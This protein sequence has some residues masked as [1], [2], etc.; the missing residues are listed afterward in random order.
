VVER[1]ASVVKELVENALDAGATRVTVEV[2]GGGVDRITVTDDGTGMDPEDARLALE[3]HAT[4]KIRTSEDLAAIGTLG[5]RG[6]ALPSIASVSRLVVTTSPDRSGL[7]TEVVA[8]RGA[9]PVVAPVRQARGTRVVVEDLFGNVPARRKF[10]KSTDAE[11]RA[12]SRVFIALALSRWDVHFTLAAKGKTLLELPAAKT[13]AER[14]S[15]LLGAAAIGEVL[16]VTASSPGLE[17]SGT[18][19]RPDVTFASKTNQWLFVNGRSVKDGAVSHAAALAARETLREDRHP[20]WL[21]FL[22]ADPALCDVNVHPQKEEVRFRDSAAVHSLIHRALGQALGE[23]KGARPLAGSSFQLRRAEPFSS[24]G[25]SFFS[26]GSAG[27]GTPVSEAISTW[28]S[29]PPPVTPAAWR[30][31]EEPA[32]S[33]LGPLRFLGQYRDSFLVAESG[34]GLVLIDQ[35]VAHERVRYE[36]IVAELG[37]REPV[38]QWLLIPVSFEATATEAL[39][40][41][42]ADSLLRGAGFLV[43]E[44][45]GRTW[46]VSAVPVETP[47]GA[48]VPFL[49]D[50][51]S[52]LTQLPDEAGDESIPA[53]AREVLAASLACR[54][55]ITINTRLR[56]EEATKLMEDLSRCADPFTC[57]HGRPIFLTLAH[58]ELE[59]RFGRSVT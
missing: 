51:L 48:I 54:G 22:K 32:V 7:G 1:P 33:P 28:L 5:F 14:F 20:G 36:R 49:K 9:R 53:R 21:L 31:E 8:D 12:I 47:S 16:E 24:P 56:P 18:L 42:R 39:A 23:G 29:P 11:L 37:Q 15:E 10:L 3:R 43:S 58:A 52:R 40:M 30:H 27:I 46:V 57:P 34:D 13:S 50:F 55:A 19:T 2:D 41:N 6:E 44:L 59:R 17:L 25:R 38:S 4:S 35:H 45:S 26:N